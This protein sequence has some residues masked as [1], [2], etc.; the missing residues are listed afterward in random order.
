[1]RFPETQV[2]TLVV[3]GRTAGPRR[4]LPVDRGSEGGGD[5]LLSF[6]FDASILAPQFVITTNSLH[7][8]KLVC[9]VIL[10]KPM[11]TRRSSLPLEGN[12]RFRRL[13]ETTSCI[14][15]S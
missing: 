5:F 2:R 9:T 6:L 12:A 3:P 15:R 14:S 8:E 7:Y 10:L 11:Y 1:M 13:C 4:T